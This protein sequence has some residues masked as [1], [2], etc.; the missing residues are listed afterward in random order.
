M[1][2][3]VT[4]ALCMMG[5]GRKKDGDSRTLA[6]KLEGKY[7]FRTEE[8]DDSEGSPDEYLT[9]EIFNVCGNIWEIRKEWI[10]RIVRPGEEVREERS[11]THESI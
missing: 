7:A 4:A 9:L 2:L 10:A 8:G 11:Q 3:L 6:E 1:T 5:A